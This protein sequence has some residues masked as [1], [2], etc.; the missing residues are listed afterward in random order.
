MLASTATTAQ[1]IGR[2]RVLATSNYGGFTS[3]VTQPI[4]MNVT[5]TPVGGA[6][7]GPFSGTCT[8]GG[9]G[10]S[11]T[12]TVAF[13]ASPG[14]NTFTGTLTAGGNTI[15]AFSQVQIVQPSTI[16]SINFT[17]NPVV[18]S[19]TLSLAAA[20]VNAGT[21]HDDVLTVNAIDKNGNTIAGSAP[22][23][24]I[25]GNPVTLS[26]STTNYQNGGRGSVVIKGP[27]RVTAANQAITFAH[28]DGNWLDHAAITATANS[29]AVNMVGATTTFTTIPYAQAFPAAGSPN[30]ITSG[31]D[32][33]LWFTEYS[34][35][36]IG[37]ITPSGIATSYPCAP[38]FQP[39]NIVTAPDGNIW[40]V[41]DGGASIGK[42][43]TGGSAV[44]VASLPGSSNGITIGPDGNVWYS[45]YSSANVGKIQT[46]GL[47]QQNYGAGFNPRGLVFGPDRTLWYL[48][49]YGTAIGHMTQS[50]AIIG[51]YSIASDGEWS[52]ELTVG[53]DGKIW[54][55][56]DGANLVESVN[57]SGAVTP[58]ALQANANPQYITVGT[59]GALWFSERGTSS[60]GRLTTAGTLSEFGSAYGI[61][62]TSTPVGITQGPDGNIWFADN[63]GNRI[64]KFVL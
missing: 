25:N 9:G 14:A 27:S 60:I 12:C 53:P 19:V 41:E 47:G 16:N 43:T 15:A 32:G 26:L 7:S 30:G 13:T 8:P 21:A 31:P 4:T 5:V 6:A 45:S 44:N 20:S 62:N 17:A 63:S 46:N 40:Y 3:T 37:K 39:S 64:Y 22:Y 2:R 51:T 10:T 24:D 34:G 56:N 55:V 52:D 35:N 61:S 42:I 36:A 48:S 38:C 28:Y 11:G 58:Y 23:V 1:S 29:S 49:Y 59:D 57:S 33:N 54:F 18:N 50:G